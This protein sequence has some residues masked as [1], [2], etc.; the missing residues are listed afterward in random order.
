MLVHLCC[1]QR[2]QCIFA[3]VLSRYPQLAPGIYL[4][5]RRNLLGYKVVLKE[6]PRTG[7]RGTS[8]EAIR[9][10]VF[11]LGLLLPSRS[12]TVSSLSSVSE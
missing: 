10:S 8:S 6:E 1:F 3:G 7:R 5:I 12:L 11:A 9:V 2:S 4:L